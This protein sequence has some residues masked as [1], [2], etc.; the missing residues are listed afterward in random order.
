M[1]SF[2]Y[3]L[4]GIAAASFLSIPVNAA[5]SGNPFYFVLAACVSLIPELIDRMAG[6]W[7][8]S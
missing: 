6:G 8:P 3:I 5:G 4:A 7:L 2:V 1:N